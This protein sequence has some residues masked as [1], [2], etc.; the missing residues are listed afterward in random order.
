MLPTPNSSI[1]SLFL[2][3]N[4]SNLALNSTKS[5][6]HFYEIASIL[7]LLAPPMKGFALKMAKYAEN[8]QK[9]DRVVLSPARGMGGGPHGLGNS[10]FYFLIK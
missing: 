4:S 6:A 5:I 1:T 3:F 8:E 9:K 7:K 2:D 10:N